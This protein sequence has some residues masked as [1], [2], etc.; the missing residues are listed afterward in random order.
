MEEGKKR[1]RK[2]WK[3]LKK[4]IKLKREKGERERDKLDKAVGRNCTHCQGKMVYQN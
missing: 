2:L 3:Q 1:K 4:F